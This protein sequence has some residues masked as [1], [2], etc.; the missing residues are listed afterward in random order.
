MKQISHIIVAGLGGSRKYN[1]GLNQYSELQMFLSIIKLVPRLLYNR[2]VKGRYLDI[3]LTHAPPFDIGDRPDLCHRGFRAFR[4][5]IRQFRPRYLIHGHIHL[6]D[7]NATRESTYFDT[8]IINAYDHVTLDLDLSL[9]KQNIR[10][11]AGSTVAASE[12]SAD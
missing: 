5:F 6:Y 9:T 3:L 10:N 4:W 1:G 7:L 11:N 2:I 8:K 12:Q